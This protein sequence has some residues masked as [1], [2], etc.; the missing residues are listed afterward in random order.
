MSVLSTEKK[1]LPRAL[2]L[3]ASHL[4]WFLQEKKQT[5]HDYYKFLIIQ[6][7]QCMDLVPADAMQ[8]T[9]EL[10]MSTSQGQTMQL[11][12]TWL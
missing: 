5:T 6:I 8:L 3:P 11:A 12:A 1:N 7:V 10:T 4:E 9:Q 2:C